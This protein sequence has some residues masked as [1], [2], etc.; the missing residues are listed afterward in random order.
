MLAGRF[1]VTVFDW[2]G[3]GRSPAAPGPWRVADLAADVAGLL[4]RLDG[5]RAHLV[6]ASLGAIVAQE[7]AAT[8]P[9][10]VRSLVL[11]GAWAATD[12][13]QHTL[14]RSW[15]RT[16]LRAP[17]LREVLDE[18]ALWTYAPDS[19]RS[20]QVERWLDVVYDEHG[21]AFDSCRQGFVS[22]AAALLDYDGRERLARVRAPA[23]VVVGE[24]DRV[25]PVDDA[26][27]VAERLDG[28]VVYVPEAGHLA[29]REDPETFA[30]LVEEFLDTVAE[31]EAL[32][33]SA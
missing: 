7:V 28:Q 29:Y 23:L 20:G 13:F 31:R 10:R 4:E 8:A 25:A 19:H 27:E 26:R 11:G 21:V 1:R 16:A 5:A 33:V 14:V 24:Q 22:A 9:D 12:A 30:T 2:R 6:G 15:I 3:I 17:Q 32:G 18:L